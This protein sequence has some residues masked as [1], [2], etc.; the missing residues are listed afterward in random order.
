MS[1]GWTDGWPESQPWQGGRAFE[2]LREG[3]RLL[4]DMGNGKSSTMVVASV[5]EVRPGE[6]SVH[7]KPDDTPTSPDA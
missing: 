3:D 6:F 7:I 4:V 1:D 2:N 5:V